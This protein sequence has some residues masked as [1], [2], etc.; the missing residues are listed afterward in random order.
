MNRSV[1]FSF[2]VMKITQETIHIL[3]NIGLF[4]ITG[5]TLPFISYGGSS[6]LSYA[7]ILAY[8]SKDNCSMVD[9]KGREQGLHKLGEVWKVRLLQLLQ[10]H[11][12]EME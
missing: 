9:S 8:I 4:P 10:V 11:L 7:L 2:I 3:M 6:L 12:K 5:I 1:V